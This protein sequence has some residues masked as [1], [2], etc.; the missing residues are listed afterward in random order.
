MHH[1]DQKKQE[2]KL[3]GFT[4]IAPYPF[5]ANMKNITLKFQYRE[6]RTVIL[7]QFQGIR[8]NY[9]TKKTAKI[10]IILFLG[11]GFASRISDAVGEYLSL[12]G[13][14]L[15]AQT[16]H[17]RYGKY[18]NRSPLWTP[19]NKNGCLKPRTQWNNKNASPKKLKWSAHVFKLHNERTRNAE[20]YLQT[21]VVINATYKKWVKAYFPAGK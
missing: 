13:I 7:P 3:I 8:K 20:N 11:L 21:R 9:P 12:Q 6:H 15:Q 17:P 1:T 14:R 2:T 4:S 18:R 5:G 16:A 10:M 19:T